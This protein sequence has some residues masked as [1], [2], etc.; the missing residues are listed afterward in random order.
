MTKMLSKI[1]CYNF[2]HKP[3]FI[4][5]DINDPSK[6]PCGKSVCKRCLRVLGGVCKIIVYEYIN[7]IT[8][9]GGGIQAGGS[10]GTGILERIFT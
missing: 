10:D 7:D 2:G 4:K 9:K 3:I 1:L 8:G 5:D 6:F